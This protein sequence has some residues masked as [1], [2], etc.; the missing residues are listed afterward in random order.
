MKFYFDCGLPRSGSTLL[1][2]ILNQNP[3]IHAGVMSPVSELME[4]TDYIFQQEQAT[5]FPKPYVFKTI[6]R[7][8]ILNYYSDRV[9]PI[10]IDK[11]RLWPDYI[12]LLKKYITPNPKLI[13]VHRDVL[14]ILAS[15]ITLIHK[16]KELSYVDKGLKEWGVN[17]CDDNRC[18]Y[19]M[20]PSGILYKSLESIKYASKH[21]AGNLH[22]I[23]YDDLTSK[24]KDT[25]DKLHL[26]L[27]IDPYTYNFNSIVAKEREDDSYYGLPT[28]HEIRSELKKISKPYTEVLSKDIIDKYKD[29][30]Y[31]D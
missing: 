27:N 24:P 11:S 19:L 1:T 25:L 31:Y 29:Y 7:S 18:H 13:C 22:M 5:V 2:A 10:I 8:L 12:G 17:F 28:M 26:F 15:W 9:E 20:Q 3:D 30:K 23:H 14:D 21:H 16:S 4:A 6:V